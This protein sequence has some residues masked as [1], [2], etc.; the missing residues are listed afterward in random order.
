MRSLARLF[1]VIFRDFFY[2]F[3]LYNNCHTVDI[4]KI[5]K[6]GTKTIKTAR[7]EWSALTAHV[8][9]LR[10]FFKVSKTTVI[11]YLHPFQLGERFSF[12]PDIQFH[13]MCRTEGLI[14]QWLDK[15][16]PG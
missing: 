16:G 15:A 10:A 7:F 11:A 3:C 1:I 2:F 12:H 14:D 5:S 9:E 6:N 4:L 8:F 13:R